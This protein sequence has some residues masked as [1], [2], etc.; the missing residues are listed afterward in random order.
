MKVKSKNELFVM[1]MT[2][3]LKSEYGLVLILLIIC[4]I[5][6]ISSPYFLKQKNLLNVTR[7]ISIVLIVAMGML[8]V[9]LS[10]EIDL[11]VGS[12]CAL[13][14]IGCAYAT[15]YT[16][17]VVLGILFALVI[18]LGVGAV[19][20]FFVVYGKIP[21]FIVTLATMGIIRGIGMVWTQGK[22]V[23]DLPEH[24]SIIG[25][26][27]VLGII[28]IST[29]ISL[30]IVFLF[31]ILLKKTKHGTYIKALGANSEAAILSTIS[32]KPYK[33]GVFILSG[34]TCAIGGII[35]TSKL[36]SAQPTASMG[37]EMDVLSGVILGGAALS[38]GVGTVVGTFLGTLI[39]GVIDNGLNLM[40]V[41][42]YYQQ[43]IKGIIILIAVLLK[44]NKNNSTIN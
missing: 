36:L 13:C 9:V 21:S 34:L 33:M 42:S 5:F 43:I 19:N 37:L 11:S 38:G 23:S 6:S 29:I 32:Y 22:P 30:V 18:G 1:K 44:Q 39:I 26:D 14:G 31:Y 12:T 41:S 27:Y 2:K 40:N 24:F 28:P 20:G 35:V 3:F 7:Q 15:T 10:G 17:S 16:N 8:S 4:I 25:T